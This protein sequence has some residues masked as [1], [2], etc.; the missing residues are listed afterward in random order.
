[1]NG[2]TRFCQ[3]ID[4]LYSDMAETEK[5]D[6]NDGGIRTGI[7]SGDFVSDDK[8]SYAYEL[9]VDIALSDGMYVKF[10]VSNNI[11]VIVGA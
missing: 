5:A 4:E 6:T 8:G 9:A 3:A 10:E 2:W 1:M 7:I 11:A